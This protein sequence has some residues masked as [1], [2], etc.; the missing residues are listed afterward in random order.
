MRTNWE[1]TKYMLRGFYFLSAALASVIPDKRKRRAGTYSQ[2]NLLKPET[3]VEGRPFSI[4]SAS[5]YAPG[6]APLT[7]GETW[8]RPKAR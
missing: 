7:R 8:R 2:I 1:T 4:F 6:L 5:E 3:F